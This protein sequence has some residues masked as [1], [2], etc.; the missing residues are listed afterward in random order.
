MII[1]E[2]GSVCWH[3]MLLDPLRL[4]RSAGEASSG[5]LPVS[6]HIPNHNGNHKAILNS[7][8]TQTQTARLE[9]E[10]HRQNSI[11]NY[12]NLLTVLQR[13]RLR[14]SLDGTVAT[15]KKFCSWF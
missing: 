5:E 11:H 12:I 14:C 8:N 3:L 4:S 2:D 6:Y 10:L 15:L 9:T 13:R 1:T 7:S